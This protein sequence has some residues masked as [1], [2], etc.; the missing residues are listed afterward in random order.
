[1]FVLNMKINFKKIKKVLILSGII[2]ATIFI[3][4]FCYKSLYKGSSTFRINDD[5]SK[6]G[7]YEIDSQ[8]YTNILRAVHENVD[9]YV[10]Q[11][12]KFTGYVYRVYDF[13]SNQFV[14]ARDMVISSDF[15]TVVVGFL[16]ESDECSSFPDNSWV[17]VEGVISKGN[18]HGGIPIIKVKNIKSVNTPSDEYVYPPDDTYVAVSNNG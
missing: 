9:S 17:E 10:G 18:Y 7:D 3:I 14:L 13:N 2:L 4:I 16:S 6:S 12:I 1:M 8:N 5:M 11:T 15:Q